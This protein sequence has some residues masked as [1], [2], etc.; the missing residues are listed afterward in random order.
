[1]FGLQ[2]RLLSTFFEADVWE[3]MIGE[4]RDHG[5]S[6]P[7]QLLENGME[8]SM[9]AE[10]D[11][12]DHWNPFSGKIWRVPNDDFYPELIRAPGDVYYHGY[13]IRKEWME[14]YRDVFDKELS[15]PEIE[16]T[17]ALNTGYMERIM[18]SR[19]VSL[20]IRRGDYV[21]EGLAWDVTA[22]RQMI[23]TVLLQMPDAVLFV[24]SDDP[25]WCRE[26]SEALGLNLAHETVI[27]EGNQG[28]NA[29]RDLQL[30]S[31]C[32]GMCLSNSAFC[33][34]AALLNKRRSL[35]INPTRRKL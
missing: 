16:S 12:V 35:V 24:F 29:F 1:M 11:N 3:Y 2:P 20:H 19:S 5:K 27:V 30:M 10:A 26:Q 21:K 9:V 13:W 6:I 8:I 31:S 18:N 15:F 34:L 33:Y 28:K 23:E 17:D 25:G 7:Q 32:E 14:A 4:K 22:F